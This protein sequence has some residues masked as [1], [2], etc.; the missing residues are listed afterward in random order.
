MNNKE[1][2]KKEYETNIKSYRNAIEAW[3][4]VKRVS[5]KD[6]SDFANLGKNFIN[7]NIT[8]P[9][10]W[11]DGLQ[12]SVSHCYGN[13][14]YAHDSSDIDDG[15]SVNI[16]FNKIS[17]RIKMYKGYIDDYEKKLN[18]FD[19]VFDE[20]NRNMKE[21]TKFAKDYGF[22]SYEVCNYIKDNCWRL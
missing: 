8:K 20:I 13:G 2:I 22:S 21:L 18:N 3:S 1:E 12:I 10:N 14:E 7:A 4:K 9:Y 16:I 5:K 11:S 17:N 19:Y 6:G 15:D